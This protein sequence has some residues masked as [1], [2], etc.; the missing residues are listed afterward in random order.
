MTLAWSCL[1]LLNRALPCTA[2]WI[3]VW[4]LVSLFHTVAD[5][6]WLYLGQTAEQEGVSGWVQSGLC[7]GTVHLPPELSIV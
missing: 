6:S 5:G 4:H 3:F 2:E 7:S 1:A